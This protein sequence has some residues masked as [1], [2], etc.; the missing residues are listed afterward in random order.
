MQP[1]TESARSESAR[2]PP[3]DK[4]IP[5]LWPAA[6][7]ALVA[8][9]LTWILLGYI[10][11]SSAPGATEVA[12]SQLAQV[13]DTDLAEALTTMSGDGAFLARFKKNAKECPSPLAWVSVVGAP[14]QPPSVIR[15]QSGTYFSPLF[16][17]SETPVRVAIPYPAPY[18]T[19][20]GSLMAVGGSATIALQPAWHVNAPAGAVARNV[21]WRVND[22]CGLKN[23]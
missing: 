6:G 20:H 18:E 13:E 10:T 4:S 14:G 7:I 19:G 9:L 1:S 5:G 11:T 15:L 21:I 3:A 22:R 17:I 16:K 12:A 8:A 2:P 23:G